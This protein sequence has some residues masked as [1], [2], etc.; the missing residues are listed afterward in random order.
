[1]WQFFSQNISKF[2]PKK[3]TLE[4]ETFPYFPKTFVENTR[5]IVGKNFT[6]R[7]LREFVFFF[8]HMVDDMQFS[9]I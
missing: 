1:M 3:I 8:F 9:L 5:K 2:S 7:V 4:N 6:Y